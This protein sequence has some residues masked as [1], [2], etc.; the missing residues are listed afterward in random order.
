MPKRKITWAKR[1]SRQFNA[2]IEYIRQDSGQN[3]DKIKEKLL[4]KINEL[5]DDKMVH[6]RP[7]QEKQR[8]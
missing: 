8:R 7:I 5:A 4:S 6:R 2:A 3:A 1:A